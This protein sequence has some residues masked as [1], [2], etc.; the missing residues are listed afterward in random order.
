M[1][2]LTCIYIHKRDAGRIAVGFTSD[3]GTDHCEF[4]LAP[5]AAQSYVVGA[6]YDFSPRQL[7]LPHE[8][9]SPEH[10][11]N[12]FKMMAQQMAREPSTTWSM[13]EEE[14]PLPTD[15]SAW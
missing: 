8:P 9:L 4:S 10:D 7:P 14:R 15:K 12:V 13:A 5:R 11:T 3:D 6:L 1:P 2:Y